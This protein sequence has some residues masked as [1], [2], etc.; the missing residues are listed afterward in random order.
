MTA[1]PS[2]AYYS[3]SARRLI[4]VVWV[5]LWVFYGVVIGWAW[6]GTP[7]AGAVLLVAAVAAQG[8]VAMTLLRMG[9]YVYAGAGRA[10]I[11]RRRRLGPRPRLWP[12]WRTPGCIENG[13]ACPTMASPARSQRLLTD[14]PFVIGATL[15]VPRAC[16]E[17]RAL[18]GALSSWGGS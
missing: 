14:R 8:W 1:Q 16:L 15:G 4:R 9:V 13:G 11:V 6:V 12:V 18:A 3:R 2:T 5:A 10:P 17:R 7:I